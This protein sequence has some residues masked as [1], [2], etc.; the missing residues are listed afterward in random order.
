M[1]QL[2][3][4]REKPVVGALSLYELN[5]RHTPTSTYVID[6]HG[7]KKFTFTL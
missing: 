3:R 6:Y 5:M 4:K 7:S 2:P 1:I